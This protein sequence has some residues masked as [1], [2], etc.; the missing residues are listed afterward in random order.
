M[1]YFLRHM[2]HKRLLEVSISDRSGVI[3]YY[4]TERYGFFLKKAFVTDL[5]G[6]VIATIGARIG[7]TPRCE[8]V[9]QNG[10]KIF[11]KQSFSFVPRY[12]INGLPYEI[13]GMVYGL[14]YGIFDNDT[15]LARVQKE[16]ENGHVVQKIE[17]SVV[18]RQQEVIAIIAAIESCKRTLFNS[19]MKR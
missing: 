1:I 7:I 10:I 13:R 15:P 12:I 6:N 9:L 16:Y 3:K 5:A 11:I 17:V 8:M 2:S 19:A 4:I 14:D 18:E